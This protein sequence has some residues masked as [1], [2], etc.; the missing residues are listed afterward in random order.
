MKIHLLIIDPQVDFCWPGAEEA[1]K[2]FLIK[3]IVAN[4]YGEAREAVMNAFDISGM[5]PPGALYVPGAHEDMLRVA[6]MIDRI[7]D[8]LDD[9]HVT[10]DS[11]HLVDIAHPI[12][13]VDS[14]GKH[15][16]PFTIVSASDVKNGLWRTTQPAFQNRKTMESAFPDKP[17]DGLEE[18]VQ[19]LET[20]GRYPLCV[21][22]AHTLIASWGYSVHP[23]LYKSLQKWE[24]SFAMVDY[25]TKGSNFWT[26]HYSAVQADV[27]D[28]DDAGTM[29]NMDLIETLEDA[30]IIL[31]AG[32]ARSHCLANTVTDIA[33]NF[34]EDSIKKMV[35]L[36]DATTDVPDPPGTTMFTDMGV[37]FVSDLTGRGM[38]VSTTTEFLK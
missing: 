9:I 4:D 7:A 24:E 12:F 11:H 13:L 1:F 23:T 25:V 28:P 22:P 5:T 36:K 8:K 35:L 38:Q 10:L 32:E 19:A 14:K 17:R 33:N 26:E 30:D 31:L 15:P 2:E 6:A 27:P 21:W 16:D 34:G 37:A 18:Y 29:L 20:N 3:G